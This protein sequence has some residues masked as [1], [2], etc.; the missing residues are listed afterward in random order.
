MGTDGGWSFVYIRPIFYIPLKI[1]LRQSNNATDIHPDQGRLMPGNMILN[2]QLEIPDKL[3]PLCKS[4][5]RLF[6][7]AASA[8][9][10]STKILCNRNFAY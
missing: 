6:C 4:F 9:K 8:L 10:L 2:K 7:A 3:L 1:T 5:E